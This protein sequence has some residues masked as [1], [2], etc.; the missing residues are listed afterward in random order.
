MKIRA[1]KLSDIPAIIELEEKAWP[2]GGAATI[3]QFKSRIDTFPEGV[4]L[5]E[6]DSDIVGVVA[7][8]I[9]SSSYL[10]QDNINW[11]KITDNGNIKRSHI[12][13]GDS[14]FGI[15]LSVDPECRNKGVGGKLLLEIG[16]MAIRRNLKMGI[17]GARMPDYYNYHKKMSPEEYLS[18]RDE[19]GKLI[20][21]EL[22][23]YEKNGL[24]LTKVIKNYF[25]DKESLDNGVLAV[26]KN[27]FYVK[28]KFLG[29]IIGWFGSL[30]FKI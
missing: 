30:V 25:P 18:L 23:F 28:N 13:D 3:N 1:A 2:E 17:L 22:R 4:I 5:A 14:L 6:H 7:G 24:K 29:N 10:E 21:S 19:N 26:W 12:A 15:D 11:A 16:K 9:I 27:P 8:E 20:D